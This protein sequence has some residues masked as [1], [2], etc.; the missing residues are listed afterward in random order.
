MVI[1]DN[2]SKNIQKIKND[3]ASVLESMSL[4]LKDWLKR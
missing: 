4:P 3:D 2:A 1:L